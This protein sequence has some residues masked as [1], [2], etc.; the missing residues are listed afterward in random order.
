MAMSNRPGGD[1]V[2][3]DG[4]LA[5]RSAIVTGGGNGIG[6]AVVERYLEEGAKVAVLER[7][8]E[9][10]RELTRNFGSDIVV[11]VG[12]VRDYASHVEILERAKQ[13]FGHVDT[14]VGNAGIYDFGRSLEE[15]PEAEMSRVFREVFEVNVL[16][17]L[18][19]LKATL[20]ELRENSGAVVLTASS[21]SYY[22]GRGGPLYVGSKHAVAG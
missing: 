5:G 10:D 7:S 20:P 18:L 21:S 8:E 2:R 4:R 3:G 13:S 22:A 1:P 6:R 14:Y 11:A 16:G 19:G 15:I 17:Y 9:S 12:D